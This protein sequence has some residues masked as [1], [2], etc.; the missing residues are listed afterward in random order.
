MNGFYDSTN[1]CPNYYMNTDFNQY[2]R[3]LLSYITSNGGSGMS[4]GRSTNYL[5]R[6]FIRHSF[7]QLIYI[8]GLG[9]IGICP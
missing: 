6:Q 1:I 2:L 7:Q 4:G 9:E 5:Y 3:G 8:E